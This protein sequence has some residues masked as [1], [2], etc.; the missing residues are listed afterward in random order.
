MTNT[1]ITVTAN[2]PL[3]HVH[4]HTSL[5]E[6]YWSGQQNS[7]IVQIAPLLQALNTCRNEKKKDSKLRSSTFS[8][9][10]T[11]LSVD[12]L[13][14][15]STISTRHR[16]WR[17]PAAT[18]QPWCRNTPSAVLEH[19][20]WNRLALR[21]FPTTDTDIAPKDSMQKHLCLHPEGPPPNG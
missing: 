8:N 1:A 7:R 3:P 5:E 18:K 2:K 15:H 11:V 16:P 6:K 14:L 10:L 13:L 4:P 20:G 17:L 19:Y 9:L 21:L 12:K